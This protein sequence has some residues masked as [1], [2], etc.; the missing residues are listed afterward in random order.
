M[1]QHQ[2]CMHI[3]ATPDGCLYLLILERVQVPAQKNRVHSQ[4]FGACCRRPFNAAISEQ[5]SS[6]VPALSPARHGFEDRIGPPSDTIV[7]EF[8]WAPH[9]EPALTTWKGVEASTWTSSG[10]GIVARGFCLLLDEDASEDGA[11]R[12]LEVDIELR[13][14]LGAS[15]LTACIAI[16]CYSSYASY[17]WTLLSR[18]APPDQK[19]EEPRAKVRGSH[20]PNL[21]RKEANRKELSG[22][23]CKKDA[24]TASDPVTTLWQ[25]IV[26]FLF[27]ALS[28]AKE[29][30]HSQLMTA[31][32]LTTK[33]PTWNEEV[34]SLVLDFKGRHILSSAKNFQ[35]ALSQKPDHVLC[36]Y[37]S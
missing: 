27:G 18:A 35:L 37:E 1:L 32:K 9:Q 23:L 7:K 16:A 21:L 22:G 30:S 29:T 6:A 19:E 33:Q 11:I 20:G 4:L 12:K 15:I 17:A 3:L 24:R 8:M 34:E 2:D 31:Q 26:A 28:W 36:Q 25:Q 5:T 14:C 10:A 13:R